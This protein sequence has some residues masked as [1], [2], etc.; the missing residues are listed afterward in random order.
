MYKTII[1][2]TGPAGL[3]AAIY[4]ARANLNPLVIEGPEPGGQLT[5]TTEVENFPGFP[6]GI[7]GPE[8][9]D[10]MRKQAEK[11]GAE[12]RTGWVNRVDLSKRPFTLS[13]EGMGELQAESLIISTGAS[14]KYLGIPGERDNVG[15]GV[16]TCATC[17]GFF[18]R[19]KKII[20]VGGGDSAMEE[21]NFLTRFASEVVLVNR[22]EELRAS[23][24]MQERA[25]A[26][27]KISWSLNRTPLEVVASDAGVQGL[28]VLNNETGKEELIEA[29]GV[30]VAIGHTPNTKFLDGQLTTDDH[31][32][33]LVTPGTTE[34]NIPGVFACGDVQDSRYR[35]AI[36]AAGTGCMAALDTERFLEAA[37]A[38]AP[39]PIA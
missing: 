18:F 33:L 7:M 30:F 26:N 31:G 2:G 15:R 8:L 23:K 6:D 27:G 10:N 4:L 3:T 29:Q 32:Y 39:V 35:Q 21:A 9:M 11:F 22:R 5:T 19:G 17:D 28:K 37:E 25:R 1:V 16:S 14:A 34:T 38:A 20:V 13:V 36:S 24:I 12:F